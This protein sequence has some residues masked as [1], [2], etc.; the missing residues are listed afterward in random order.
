MFVPFYLPCH[1][2]ENTYDVFPRHPWLVLQQAPLPTPLL[3]PLLTPVLLQ[4]QCRY[5]RRDGAGSNGAGDGPRA[6]YAF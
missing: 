1:A 5:R 3:T 4:A 2:H 6:G